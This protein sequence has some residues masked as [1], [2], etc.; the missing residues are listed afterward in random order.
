MAAIKQINFIDE[1][2]FVIYKN[3][4]VIIAQQKQI[5]F[6]AVIANGHDKRSMRIQRPDF[7]F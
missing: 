2:F 4:H 1:R 5:H 6:I 3:F 7:I